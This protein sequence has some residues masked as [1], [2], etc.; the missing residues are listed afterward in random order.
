VTLLAGALI[1]YGACGTPKLLLQVVVENFAAQSAICVDWGLA[2]FT[3]C[4]ERWG[5]LFRKGALVDERQRQGRVRRRPEVRGVQDAV[6]HVSKGD[7]RPWP[8]D[9]GSHFRQADVYR[10][11]GDQK[12]RIHRV[13][14]EFGFRN[15]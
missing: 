8:A 12:E 15:F 3:E 7:L 9:Q 5:R 14:H 1:V 2:A 4:L 13:V 6:G 10:D 11:V